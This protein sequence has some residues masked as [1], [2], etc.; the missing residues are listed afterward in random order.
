MNWVALGLGFLQNLFGW[1]KAREE[2]KPGQ[3]RRDEVQ[4]IRTERNDEIKYN[5]DAVRYGVDPVTGLVRY[6]KNK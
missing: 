3:Q 6:P 2:N 5:E 4:T 1:K